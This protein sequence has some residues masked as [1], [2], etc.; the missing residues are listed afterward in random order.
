MP[1][2]KKTSWYAAGLHFDCQACGNCCCG[3]EEGYIWVTK[4]EIQLIAD[5]L[6]ISAGQL[7][8]KYLKRVGLRTTIIENPI[9]KDCIFLKTQN[10]SKL[11]Q[12][13]SVR[14]NQCRNWPFW[15]DNLTSP[16]DWNHAA[17]RCPGI[18]RGKL[19]SFEQIQKIKK[20]KGNL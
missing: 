16:D 7:H 14:P 2:T 18:N 5:F 15:T 8:K 20:N 11:C 10:G 19:Y 9:N 6:K 17:K 3:P 4:P 1:A 13:Y 12:I